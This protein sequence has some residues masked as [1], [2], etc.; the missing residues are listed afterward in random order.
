DQ[1]QRQ[2][3]GVGGVL[4]LPGPASLHEVGCPWLKRQ[5]ARDILA[6]PAKLPISRLIPSKKSRTSVDGCRSC[7]L[8]QSGEIGLAVGGPGRGSRQVWLA[9]RKA[10][11]SRSRIVQPLGSECRC[12]KYDR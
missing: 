8:P 10:G 12:G 11:D 7:R 6:D 1:A 5:T 2:T 3:I 9:V 4:E